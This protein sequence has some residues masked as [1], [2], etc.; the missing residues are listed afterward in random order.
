MYIYHIIFY[1]IFLDTSPRELKTY[2]HTEELQKIFIDAML[3]IIK[4]MKAT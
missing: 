4:K 1:Y 2:V 3:I